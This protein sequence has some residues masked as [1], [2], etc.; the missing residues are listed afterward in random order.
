MKNHYILHGKMHM[1]HIYSK[2]TKKC[3]ININS[4]Q[5]LYL[6]AQDRIQ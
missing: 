2:S 5:W 6:G 3:G 1:L 4:A